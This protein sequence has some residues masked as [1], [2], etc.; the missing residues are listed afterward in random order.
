MELMDC[1]AVGSPA[2][3]FF[4]IVVHPGG[5]RK[6]RQGGRAGA[7]GAIASLKVEGLAAGKQAGTSGAEAAPL[8]PDA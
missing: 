4:H 5:S 8:Y 6:S 1:T 2:A 3:P 7:M